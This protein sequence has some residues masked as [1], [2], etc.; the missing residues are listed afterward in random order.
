ML[1]VVSVLSK[2]NESIKENADCVC[3]C[4]CSYFGG[5]CDLKNL[6]HIDLACP[7]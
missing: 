7:L 5:I 6:L 1:H 2:I 4:V 3:V